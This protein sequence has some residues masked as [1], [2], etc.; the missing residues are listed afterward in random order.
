VNA[1]QHVGISLLMLYVCAGLCEAAA[2]VTVTGAH[3]NVRAVP[4][5]NGE[6]VG[7]VAQGDVL[8]ATGVREG[9]WAEILPPPTV[10]GWLYGELVRDGEVAALSVRVRSGPGIG[11]R[12]IGEIAKGSKVEAQESRGDWVRISPPP[13]CKVWI[14]SEFIS[15]GG[16]VHVSPPDVPESTHETPPTLPP[17]EASAPPPVPETRAPAPPRQVV[18]A[19]PA[20]VAP[21][22]KG[23][24]PAAMAPVHSRPE[25]KS[26]PAPSRKPLSV[27]PATL[28]AAESA[29]TGWAESLVASAPQGESVTVSGVL[30]PSGFFPFRRPSRYRLVVKDG[31]SPAQTSCYVV[32]E[33]TGIRQRLGEQVTLVGKKYWVQG[34]REPV[35]VVSE[36]R[37]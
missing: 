9:G 4:D 34:F 23:P 37:K 3:V 36:F 24:P 31:P 22:H 19:P 32:G 10:S 21:L 18:R 25:P 8:T 13:S 20:P 27:P 35:V 11:Y 7:Q 16:V 2:R 28:R 5:P 30:R 17:V 33:P 15:G 29:D 14:S 6:I 12:P 1:I 26:P